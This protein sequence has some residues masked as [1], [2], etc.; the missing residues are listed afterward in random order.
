M[1]SGASRLLPATGIDAAGADPVQY[2]LELVSRSGS[3]ITIDGSSLFQTDGY[4]WNV[5]D[6]IDSATHT[7]SAPVAGPVS[8]TL[9][10][11]T[12]TPALFAGVTGAGQ[13]G[14]IDILGY[15][16]SD[17]ALVSDLS[18]AVTKFAQV[19]TGAA[20]VTFQ[21]DPSAVEIRHAPSLSAAGLTG[22][23]AGAWN[24]TKNIAG[25]SGPDGTAP[26]AAPSSLPTGGVAL[27]PLPPSDI[28]TLENAGLDGAFFSADG[29]SGGVQ[30]LDGSSVSAGSISLA[31]LAITLQGNE[32][33]VLLGLNSP[34][35]VL[36]PFGVTVGY[37]TGGS[38][39][40]QATYIGVSVTDL[41]AAAGGLFTATM[42]YTAV[43][44]QSYSGGTV[45]D[46]AAWDLTN[47]ST[48]FPG[49]IPVAMP[50]A[51]PT[52]TGGSLADSYVVR[53][54]DSAGNP[55]TIGGDS[56]FAINGYSFSVAASGSLGEVDIA[57]GTSPLSSLMSGLVSS[58]TTLS[59]IDILGYSNTQDSGIPVGTLLNDQS[60]GIV[61]GTQL[62][63]GSGGADLTAVFRGAE[64]QSSSIA[65]SG[66]LTAD[67]SGTWLENTA[68]FPTGPATAPS[69]EPTN[70]L[71]GPSSETYYVRFVGA[72]G[73]A[74][75][76][77]GAE[78]FALGAA[79]AQ[80]S[81]PVTASTSLLEIGATTLGPLSLAIDN[82]ALAPALF[83]SLMS[84]T[85][86][87]EIDVLGYDSAGTLVSD[88]SFG[89]A[90]GTGLS[91]DGS[92]TLAFDAAYA[93]VEQRQQDT[94]GSSGTVS[95]AW[96]VLTGTPT[97]TNGGSGTV[98]LAAPN[99]LPT[100]GVA[101]AGPSLK[102]FVQIVSSGT[103]LTLDGGQLFALSG[104]STGAENTVQPAGFTAGSASFALLGLTIDDPGLA[105]TLLSDLTSGSAIGE[106]DI[107]SYN[108]ATR[109]LVSEANFGKVRF[110]TADLTGNTAQFGAAYTTTEV[111]QVGP[112]STTS[113]SW[114]IVTNNGTLSTSAST[115]ATLS[116]AAIATPPTLDYYVSFVSSAGTLAADGAQ[117]FALSGVQVGASA[118]L[119]TPGPATMQPL[120]LSLTQGVLTPTLFGDLSAGL[121][122]STVDVYG[123]SSSSHLLMSEQQF[124][125][126]TVGSLG[127]DGSGT[128]GI[129]LVYQSESAQYSATGLPPDPGPLVS[130]GALTIAPAQSVDVTA[131]LYGLVTPGLSGD[132]DTI[133]SVSG[134]ASIAAGDV[135]YHAPA[136]DGADSFTF[137]VQNEFGQAATGTVNVSVVCFLRG[138]RILTPQGE[139]P[140]EDLRIGD[141]VR[142]F[143]GAARKLRWIGMGRALVT[144]RNRDRA[145]PV[146]VRRHALAEFVPHRDL[147]ITRGH[148]V[149]LDG[150]L[151]PVE[152]LVNHRSIA[153]VKDA[154]AVEYYHLELDSH[155]VLIAEGAAA[156]SY[157]EDGNHALFLNAATR[158]SRRA[159]APCA[160]VLHEHPTVKRVWRRLSDRAGRLD[161]E[162]TD[163]PDLHLLADQRRIAPAGRDGGVWRFRLDAPAGDL[164]IVSR[165][166]IPSMIGLEQ[167]Q[168]RLG[169]AVR[170]IDLAGAVLAW[171]DPRLAAGFH[172]PE[173]AER[174]RW[175]DGAARLPPELARRLPAGAPI[176]I[177]VSGTLPY[178]LA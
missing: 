145:T 124:T 43:D 27:P 76:A 114:N 108:T 121:H 148:I 152:E 105:T 74:L 118:D 69:S 96:N 62:S 167:D 23:P 122:F 89:L 7:N 64:L 40:G 58:G 158:P 125:D 147:Y 1:S 61:A 4:S 19:T 75:T 46:S 13:I 11:P 171:D 117:M 28:V 5:A 98:P 16:T 35:S 166:A 97:F 129:S 24:F 51:R 66:T 128:A 48:T 47:G 78:Y 175:T 14:E 113:A 6:S 70:I 73:T 102:S 34:L 21:A 81:T 101:G 60:F 150:V 72:G 161:L 168:R 136:T 103:P 26:A 2:Y 143:S 59:E 32:L 92:G 84:G 80:D 31:P 149:F 85:P 106:I 132:T 30:L 172:G 162:F 71:S 135:I 109:T 119:A 90:I 44:W 133:T 142:T 99:V 120:V 20:S 63:F 9:A 157:R 110:A 107:L 139:V 126:A 54:I 67:P 170:R 12:L 176:A 151:I 33:N 177:E 123:Y 93:S 68:A 138:T 146:V 127:V 159:V 160:P 25:F 165:H 173:P 29:I 8:V 100:A 52:L 155:D 82:T 130:N 22:G 178:P 141:R 163:D 115:P 86:L 15:Q 174:H 94:A 10:I 137:T 88:S 156:E 50:T 42:S 39:V 49:G 111:Q 104:Y 45:S 41:A 38:L 37:Y 140:V 153:W 57:L 91:L 53:L 55:I 36:S 131:L 79:G 3:V 18:F 116:A 164:R 17:G 154:G 56:L 95:T 65:S 144:P 112:T 83:Q 134:N 169:V 77:G 87:S